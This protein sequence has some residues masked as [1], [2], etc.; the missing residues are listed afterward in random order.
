MKIQKIGSAKLVQDIL[1]SLQKK[2]DITEE[3][4]VLRSHRDPKTGYKHLEWYS[5]AL[6][7]KIWAIGA[8]TFLAYKLQDDSEGWPEDEDE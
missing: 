6:N 2:A 7:S 5:T 3:L 4:I 1:D 8:L